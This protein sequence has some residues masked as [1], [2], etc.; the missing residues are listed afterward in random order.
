MLMLVSPALPCAI[1]YTTTHKI[2]RAFLCLYCAGQLHNWQNVQ[3]N[4]LAVFLNA[5]HAAGLG[6]E[7]SS[8]TILA[9][10]TALVSSSSHRCFYVESM[11]TTSTCSAPLRLGT[12]RQMLYWH[13]LSLVCERRHA[14]KEQPAVHIPNPYH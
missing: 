1:F 12:Q 5:S 2:S 13:H 3:R 8:C 9:E 11:Q 14:S 4:M 10:D 6:L 7:T